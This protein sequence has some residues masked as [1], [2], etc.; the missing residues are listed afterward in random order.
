M[1]FILFYVI[2]GYLCGSILFSKISFLGLKR[3]DPTISAFDHNPGAFNAFRYNGVGWGLFTLLGDLSKGFFPVW[4]YIHQTFQFSTFYWGIPFVLVSPVL[5]HLYPIFFK[6][7]GGE[8]I[9]TTF[10][11]LLAL[12][13][14]EISAWPLWTVIFLFL[15]MKFL[16]GLKP[17]YYLTIGVYF[18]MPLF[19]FFEPINIFVWCGILFIGISVL[20]KL[21]FITP[22]PQQKME[23]NFLSWKH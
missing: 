17:D 3:K 23:V 8:G 12:W 18:M 19:T 4:L 10:G 22:K 11:V 13:I 6:F 5:G 2:I 15:I 16:M 1:N 20:E 7:Q 14:G 21:L 9:S